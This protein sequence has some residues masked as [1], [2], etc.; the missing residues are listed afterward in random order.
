VKL[1]KIYKFFKF[2]TMQLLHLVAAETVQILCNNFKVKAKKRM[3]TN[4]F[5]KI[6]KVSSNIFHR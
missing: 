4:P 6:L 1:F 2:L 5:A 3:T